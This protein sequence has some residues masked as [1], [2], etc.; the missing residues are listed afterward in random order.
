MNF[1]LSVFTS[2][3]LVSTLFISCGGGAKS[4]STTTGW[5]YNDPDNGGFEV[6][7]SVEQKTGP[8]LVLI[9][10]GTFT[11]GRVEQDV[12]Y[13]W[14]NVPRRVTVSSFYMDETE[15][16]NIDYREY[17]YWLHRVFVDYPQV[18]RNALP[19]T[20]VWRRPLAYNEPYVLYYFRHPSYNEYPVV[21]V[22]WLQATDYCV[23][24][25]DRVNEKLLIDED[26]LSPDPN[27]INEENFNTDSYLA[28]QYEGIINKNMPS[29]DPNQE[30]RRVQLEDGI[31][32]PRYRLPSEAEWEYA[33]LALIG[34]SYEERV[35][36]RRVYPWNGHNVRQDIKSNRGEMRA[37]FVRG[38][39]DMMGVA[40]DLNDQ[41]SI[42]APVNSYW[43]NDYGLY[44]MAGN[45]N[46]WVQD[47]YRPL[48][49]QDVDEF[50]PFRGN[51]FKQLK[52][53]EEGN[54]AEKDSLGRLQY[55]EVPE[56][57]AINRWNYKKA[58]YINYRDGDHES[59]IIEGG[60]WSA[61]AKVQERGSTRMYKMAPNDESSLV[62][63][64]SRV[65]KGGSWRD[66]AY[67]MSPGTRRFL[68][69]KS[70]RDDLG[71]RCAMTRVG[72]PSG[73]GGQ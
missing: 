16:R 52:K 44:N 29:L 9:E 21:G 25:T 58:D 67:W 40:G 30:T 31:L 71:F 48:S 66:R 38:R 64:Q 60:D 6:R 36:E 55:V 50:N 51:V 19:D 34:N 65:Y 10:G 2:L 70:S 23:W 27:Q 68:D 33:A 26:I 20:L 53:D 18:H 8:G 59:S 4:G 57:E 12:I 3:A 61:G 11:M 49:F 5:A 13:E 7:P 28:G 37:N 22:N 42:P 15:V 45:V 32:L 14:N 41:A 47:V 39:G 17:L 62:S 73:K 56:E 63:D 24:R 46:E 43:P 35:Y 54:T 1:K 72:S 69:E